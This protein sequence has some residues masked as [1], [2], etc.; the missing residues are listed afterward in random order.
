[1]FHVI[2]LGE[3]LRIVTG[4]TKNV[5]QNQPMPFNISNDISK[6]VKI[7]LFCVGLNAFL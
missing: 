2:Y 7:N 1:M 6:C 3:E 5:I 4:S